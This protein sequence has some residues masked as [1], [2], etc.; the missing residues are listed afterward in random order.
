VAWSRLGEIATAKLRSGDHVHVEGRLV[1][2]TYD[3]QYGNGK[4]PVIVKQTYWQVR[5]SSIRKLNRADG[6]PGT[7]P[8]G[9]K[10]DPANAAAV[11]F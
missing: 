6:Q 10:A 7:S 9:T 8:R 1:S 4:K 11:P 5:A 3:R 2:S